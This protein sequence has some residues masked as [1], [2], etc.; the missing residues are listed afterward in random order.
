MMELLKDA[1][2]PNGSPECGNHVAA[3]QYSS[4]SKHYYWHD[5]TPPPPSDYSNFSNYTDY[6]ADVFRTRGYFS[7]STD[8]A[9]ALMRVRTEDLEKTRRQRTFIMVFTD[10]RSS[11]TAGQ[12]DKIQG[13]F[14]E[15]WRTFVRGGDMVSHGDSTV[16]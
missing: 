5:F 2:Q 15:G 7:G 11:N 4:S 6:V 3:R 14:F 13:I 9:G 8:T 12:I 1:I 10:G 16:K